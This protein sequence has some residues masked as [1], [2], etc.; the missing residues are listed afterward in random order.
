MQIYSLDLD[1]KAARNASSYLNK[2]SLDSSDYRRQGL[3]AF[4][5][6]N[7]RHLENRLNVECGRQDV[8]RSLRQEARTSPDCPPEF[9]HDDHILGHFAER[10]TRDTYMNFV[11]C[12]LIS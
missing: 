2:C 9:I 11:V 6:Q 8:K 1:C 12:E 10:S 5:C 7:V 4:D 3:K